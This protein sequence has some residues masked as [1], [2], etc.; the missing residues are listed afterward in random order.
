M[1]PERRKTKISGMRTIP[2]EKEITGATEV[3]PYEKVSEI[4]NTQTKFAVADCICRK[5]RKIMG[6]GCDK[7]MEACMTFGRQ[8]IIILRTV[9]AGKSLEKKQRRSFSKQKNR[10]SSIVLR[11][12]KD[13]GLYLQLLRV[14]LWCVACRQQTQYPDSNDQIKL[15]R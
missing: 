2:V 7:L 4:L 3:E 15:L 5:E 14:L 9:S 6:K 11:I 10:G 1:V 13:E 12:R 8:R